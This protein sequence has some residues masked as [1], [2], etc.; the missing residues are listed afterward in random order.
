[1]LGVG[2]HVGNLEAHF[3]VM[4]VD[5]W[6][7]QQRKEELLLE[8]AA[9]EAKQAE[10]AAGSVHLHILILHLCFLPFSASPSQGPGGRHCI[11]ICMRGAEHFPIIGHLYRPFVLPMCIGQFA[12]DSKGDHE[13]RR[14]PW[15]LHHSLRRVHKTRCMHSESPHPLVG[16]P[17]RLSQLDEFQCVL[18]VGGI[19]NFFF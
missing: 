12:G 18:S 5:C 7:C 19:R 1:M 16:K 14:C 17:C 15:I 10:C 3:L 11:P 9:L 4:G 13:A 2:F 6:C 8:I